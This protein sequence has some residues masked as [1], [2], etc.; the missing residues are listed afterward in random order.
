MNRLSTHKFAC[1]H[2]CTHHVEGGESVRCV[3]RN[4]KPQILNFYNRA[5]QVGY[6]LS[7]RQEERE[8]EVEKGYDD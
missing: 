1:A 4:R 8:R 5:Q 3:T 6:L 2:M 7:D